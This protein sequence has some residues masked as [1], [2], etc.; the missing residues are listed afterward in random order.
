LVD[1]AA[2]NRSVRIGQGL[3]SAEAEVREDVNE[4]VDLLSGALARTVE[5]AGDVESSSAELAQSMEDLSKR[6]ETQ[7]AVVTETAEALNEFTSAMSDIAQRAN[8]VSEVAA[9]ARA[10]ANHGGEVVENAIQAMSHIRRSS[11]EISKIIE[12]IEDISFQTNLLALNA[13][14]E[15]ARA[16]DKGLGFAVVASEVRQLSQ[17]TSQAANQVKELIQS[18]GAEVQSGSDLVNEV[19]VALGSIMSGITKASEMVDDMST[20]AQA[21]STALADMNA[22]VDVINQNTQVN[23]AMSEEIAAVGQNMARSAATLMQTV[24]GFQL[25]MEGRLD[26]SAP[27]FAASP[28]TWVA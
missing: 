14:V 3:T 10:D 22:S 20:D 13:G 21:K 8:V 1:R 12:V 15:A 19:G 11:Q 28:A 9:T 2:Q 26:V 5:V 7:A 25:Q 23:A 18:S 24:D 4:T 6:N 17:R 27:G 16:G